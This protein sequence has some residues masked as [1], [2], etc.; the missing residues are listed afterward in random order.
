MTKAEKKQFCR[1][2]IATVTK[3]ILKSI[4]RVPEYWTGLELRMLIRDRFGEAVFGAEDRHRTKAYR[5][6]CLTHNLP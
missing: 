3:D 2:L 4:D 6:D 5:N 1:A